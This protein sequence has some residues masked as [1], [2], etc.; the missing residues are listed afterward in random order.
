[1][2]RKYLLGLLAAIAGASF[3]LGNYTRDYL[4]YARDYLTLSKLPSIII[5]NNEEP[6]ALP[7]SVAATGTPMFTGQV[8]VLAITP[9]SIVV[10]TGFNKT[11]TFAVAGDIPVFSAV[12]AGQTGKGLDDMRVGS[13]VVVYW[14]TT[15]PQKASSLAFARD[16]SLEPSS[17]EANLSL[18]GVVTKLT[19]T[20]VT[21]TSADVSVSPVTIALDA[22]TKILAIVTSGQ[23]GKSLSEGITVVA[24][25]LETAG[26]KTTA[27]MITISAVP[28]NQ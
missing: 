14:H 22:S 2:S 18:A 3:W 9:S 11:R 28:S 24:S 10:Q 13:R 17:Y 5:E 15:D 19:D 26:G 20:D 25:G 1:M 21:V 8:K 16:R 23:Q 27:T 12:A 6:R 4:L 7:A